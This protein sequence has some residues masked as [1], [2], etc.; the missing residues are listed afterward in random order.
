MSLNA[1]GENGVAM[2]LK[3]VHIRHYKSLDNVQ[4]EFSNPIT[5]LVGP[6]AVG[7][8]NIVDCLRFVRDAVAIDLEHAVSKRGGIA[9]VLQYSKTKPFK[10]SVRLELIDDADNVPRP[11]SYEFSVQSETASNYTV[12]SE[13]CTYFEA[14]RADRAQEKQSFTR[15][16]AGTVRSSVDDRPH[17]LAP[18][19]LALGQLRGLL[20]PLG[21]PIERFVRDWR[22]SVLY[23]NLLREP[24]SPDR[25][26]VLA[27][28]GKNW[29]SVIKALRRTAR[30]KAALDRVHEA[31]RSVVPTFED[32]TVSTVGSYLVPRFRFSLGKDDT[33]AF[34]PVQLS[35][36]TLRIFGILLALYQVPAPRLLVIEEPEQS[37]QPGVL[38]VLADAFREC[39]EITQIIVTTHS[40]HFI[41][42]FQPEQVRVV[43][44]EKGATRVSAVKR[45]Q[46][47][48]VKK[49]LMS[50]QDFMLAEGLLPEDA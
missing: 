30:G 13:R 23:P 44:V 20:R 31:M 48:A 1:S 19:Q 27:E 15:D 5:V 36:G 47:E 26:K 40:P 37:V 43:A 12:D 24:A 50:M 33:V 2:F 10:V 41:D 32:V 38:G 11:A 4:I 7:K 9:R 3:S 16:K 49:R 18:D 45:T 17:R 21:W 35:D 34:D 8:S 6:N 14:T 42:H 28:D 46:I 29:A 39:A 22:Y 25:D